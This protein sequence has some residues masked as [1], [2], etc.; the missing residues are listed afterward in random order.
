[1]VSAIEAILYGDWKDR[2][3]GARKRPRLAA[4]IDEAFRSGRITSGLASVAYGT[5]STLPTATIPNG[6]YT[7]L[8]A[9]TRL[10]F[11]STSC[12]PN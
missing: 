3:P 4:L 5:M 12:W 1:M 11:L 2:H 8:P 10:S 6:T 7:T 9:T